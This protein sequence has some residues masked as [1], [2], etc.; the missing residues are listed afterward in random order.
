[1]LCELSYESS[2][3]SARGGW[4]KSPI[5]EHLE[6]NIRTSY[7]HRIR[8]TYKS[9]LKMPLLLNFCPSYNKG[10]IK[11]ARFCYSYNIRFNTNSPS[12]SRLEAS[13]T[14]RS[15]C[16]TNNTSVN[17]SDVLIALKSINLTIAATNAG[18]LFINNY[19]AKSTIERVNTQP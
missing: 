4:F 8:I 16:P 17:P 11:D 7:I 5:V 1:V 15:T 13:I 2:Y 10:T 18:L 3:I 12:A 9:F 19:L 14:M 6:V